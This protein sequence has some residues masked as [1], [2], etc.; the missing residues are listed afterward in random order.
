M[1]VYGIWRPPVAATQV[2][3]KLTLHGT[4]LI[5]GAQLVEEEDG[6]PAGALPAACAWAFARLAASGLCNQAPRSPKL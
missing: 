6:R 4:F 3:A 1:Y 2:K 5:E